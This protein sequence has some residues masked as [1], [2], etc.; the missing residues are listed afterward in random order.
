MATGSLGK[1]L[2]AC[3]LNVSEARRKDLV[4]TVA[5]SAL[6]NAEG[7]FN[8]ILQQWTDSKFKPRNYY[9][10]VYTLLTKS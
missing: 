1:R 3:L 10:Y 2:V 5:K 8:V 4:E 6:Y 7:K 9:Q